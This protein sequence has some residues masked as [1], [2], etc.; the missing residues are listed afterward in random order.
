MEVI[1]L[2]KK[3]VVE[4][5]I[6][7]EECIVTLDHHSINHFQKINK[8]GLLSIYAAMEETKKTGNLELETIIQ[9]LGSMIRK[10]KTDEIVGAR[11]LEQFDSFSIL[12]HLTPVLM[13]VLGANLP[14]AKDESEKK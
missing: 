3:N 13:E 11:W 7:G 10:K 4:I 1:N 8:K 14:E 6:N 12:E 9:L 2:K 5:N